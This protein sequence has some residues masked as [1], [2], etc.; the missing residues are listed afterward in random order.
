[1]AS[2]ILTCIL[3]VTSFNRAAPGSEG[4]GFNPKLQT[5]LS[6]SEPQREDAVAGWESGTET[7]DQR[8]RKLNVK[9]DFLYGVLPFVHK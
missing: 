4:E 1:M 3:S 9:T 2:L 6:P 5:L 7:N 8:K